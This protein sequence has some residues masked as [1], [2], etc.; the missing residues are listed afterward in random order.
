MLDLL[1][2]TTIFVKLKNDCYWQISG[3]P[4]ADLKPKCWDVGRH[5]STVATINA[6][7][8]ETDK[9]HQQLTRTDP[10][11]SD[12]PAKRRRKDN[13]SP[14]HQLSSSVDI[15]AQDR[16]K[17]IKKQSSKQKQHPRNNSY[18]SMRKASEVSFS[19]SSIFHARPILHHRGKVV[20]GFPPNRMLYAS[21]INK[22]RYIIWTN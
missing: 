11:E 17:C 19:R 1:T 8:K 21:N 9:V 13:P 6:E 15:K 5:I 16:N 20:T 7:S 4:V 10:F 12:R 3:Q 22:S 18:S 2:T 14:G